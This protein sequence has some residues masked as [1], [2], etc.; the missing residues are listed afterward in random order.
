MQLSYIL[1]NRMKSLIIIQT[2]L[3]HLPC[4]SPEKRPL[5]ISKILEELKVETTTIFAIELT[6]FSLESIVRFKG[7][8]ILKLSALNIGHTCNFKVKIDYFKSPE[9]ASKIINAC[10]CKEEKAKFC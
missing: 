8:L 10:D 6:L 5:Q 4:L 3:H 1:N 9:K 7:K 2:T